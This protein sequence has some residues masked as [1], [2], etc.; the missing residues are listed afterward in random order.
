MKKM[1]PILAVA[2]GTAFSAHAAE[3]AGWYLGLDG[4]K[5]EVDGGSQSFDFDMGFAVNLGYDFQVSS[6]FV[7]GVEIEYID[8]GSQKI[9]SG[10]AFNKNWEII[11]VDVEEGITAFNLNIRPKYYVY[12]NFYVGGI[13]GFGSIEYSQEATKSGYES[14]EL[15]SESDSAMNLGLELGYQFDSGWLVRGGVRTTSPEFFNHEFDVTTT[16]LGLGYKF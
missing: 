4:V 10:K 11:S 3:P 7:T 1:L 14:L 12:N 16:F 13:L 9:G 5:S 15:M 2:M 8:Y 6:Q